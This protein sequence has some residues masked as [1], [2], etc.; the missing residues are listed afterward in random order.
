MS[1]LF[2]GNAIST[3]YIDT[4]QDS[5]Y[6]SLAALTVAIWGY[7]TANNTNYNR[8]LSKGVAGTNGA[9]TFGLVQG[10][11]N[12]VDQ[13]ICYFAI[14]NGSIHDVGYTG[15]V[16]PSA[17]AWFHQAGTWDGTNARN[18]VNGAET[19]GSPVS[20][21]G[22]LTNNNLNLYIGSDPDDVIQLQADSFPGR[23]ADAAFWNAA[24]FA[25]EVAALARGVSPL[26]IRPTALLGYWPLFGVGSPE[27]DYSGNGNN[28]SITGSVTQADHAPVQAPF[29]ADE[30]QIW[31][32]S[33][34]TGR[35]ISPN[36]LDGIGGRLRGL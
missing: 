2:V 30:W 36:A 12:G 35:L 17:N 24:L 29:G 33:V 1:R 5:L 18:Y 11:T 34:V 16:V 15:G 13:N 28:G 27:P 23:L 9:R 21:T 8:L 26:R 31:V 7:R 22:S 14:D 10:G 19:P 3:E 6:D 4:G 32:P 20:V 25:G